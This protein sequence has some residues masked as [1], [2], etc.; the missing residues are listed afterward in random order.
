MGNWSWL[1]VVWTLV[2]I[3]G[4]YFSFRNIKDGLDDIES[5]RLAPYK[6]G[7]WKI[8]HL[9]ARR[10]ILLDF[11]RIIPQIVFI[12]VGI[13]AGLAPGNP[14]P[15]P[16]GIA[17][18]FVFIGVSLLYTLASAIDHSTRKILISAGMHLETEN[19]GK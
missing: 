13:L 7:R 6:N 4:A 8:V 18:G 14:H 9:V 1:E 2:A 12:G 19:H 3:L 16:T 11:L 10:S 15:S 17:A 5:L